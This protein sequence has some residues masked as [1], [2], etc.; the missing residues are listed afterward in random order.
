L[1]KKR[2][3]GQSGIQVSELCLGAMYFGWKESEEQSIDR[4]NQYTEV[5]GNFVDTA[6]M[7]AE[8]HKGDKDYYGKDFNSFVDGG[9]ERLIG[10]WMKERNNRN[11]MIIA[12]KLGCPYPGAEYGTSP[13]QIEEECEKSLKRLCTDYI[14]LLYLH[15]NDL[16]YSA[17]ELMSTLDKLVKSG[18]VRAIG[19]SNFPA[20]RLAQTQEVAKSCGFTKFSCIQQKCSYIRPAPGSNF[21]NQF[22][23][24]VVANDELFDYVNYS[25]DITILGYSPLM[26]GYYNNRQKPLPWQFMGE[27]TKARIKALDKISEKTGYKPA[28]IVYYWLMNSN[29]SILPLVAASNRQQFEEALLS[30]E[31]ELSQ[32][33]M[34]FLTQA[35]G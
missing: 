11:N 10:K 7:Y 23:G 5:G 25:K 14:D 21:K 30:T 28:Q 17:E 20:W 12:T 19:A 9:S 26:G 24:Q 3:L 13:K 4:L 33:D 2:E 22:G 1:L 16:R 15:V 34:T 8:Y 32:E 27:D 35:K 18:K 29:P 6:N 31:I